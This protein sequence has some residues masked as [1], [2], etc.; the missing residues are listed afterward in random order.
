L[1]LHDALPISPVSTL[2]RSNSTI[3]PSQFEQPQ[4]WVSRLWSVWPAGKSEGS[5]TA[6]PSQ[7][8]FAI[9]LRFFSTRAHPAAAGVSPS[10]E[11]TLLTVVTMRSEE[12]R[13]GKGVQV[14]GGGGSDKR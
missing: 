2:S 13:V 14:D 7:I 1:S 5:I 9:T 12:R 3:Q 11:R 4:R 10:K 6:V 8:T